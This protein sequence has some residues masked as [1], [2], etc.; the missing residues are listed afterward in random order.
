MK[1]PNIKDNETAMMIIIDTLKLYTTISI[2]FVAVVV[3][4]FA[5]VVD[6]ESSLAIKDIFICSLILFAF[7]IIFS[8]LDINAFVTQVYHHQINIYHNTARY[9]YIAVMFLFSVSLILGFIFIYQVMQHV[10]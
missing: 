10:P 9:L 4:L 5:R 2:G 3:T 7:T 6:K 8:I 1:R